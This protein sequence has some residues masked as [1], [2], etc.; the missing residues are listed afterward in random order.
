MPEAMATRGDSR[1]FGIS[2]YL[3]LD[4]R[5]RQWP[6]GTLLVPED[7]GARHV[8]WPVGQTGLET[9]HRIGRDVD[10]PIFAAF[11]LVDADGLLRPVDIV[12][13][14]VDHLRDPQ[15]TPE[16]EQEERLIHGV[17]DLCKQLL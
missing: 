17:V 7:S 14:E 15:A 10:P 12:H 9:C 8:C 16:H 6:V 1:G 4:R 3:L 2:L 11:A 13:R 5:D